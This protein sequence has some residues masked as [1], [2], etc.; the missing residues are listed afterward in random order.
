MKPVSIIF[1]IVSVVLVI[2]GIVLCCV[3][4]VKANVSGVPLYD[5]AQ[6]ENGDAENEYVFNESDVS[7]IKIDV[8]S[9]DVKV[10]CGAEENK[11]VVKNIT[12]NNIVSA[13]DCIINN[14][15][16]SIENHNL[17]SLTSLAQG[18]FSFKGFRYGIKY[19][20]DGDKYDSKSKEVTVY[21]KDL[22]DIRNIDVSV[23]EGSIEIEGYDNSTDYTLKISNG[24]ITLKNVKTDSEVSA[25]VEKTG[26]VFFENVSCSL[27]DISTEQGNI[28]VQLSSNEIKCVNGGGDTVIESQNDLSQYNYN[29]SSPLGKILLNG[30]DK[31]SEYKAVDAMLQCEMRITAANGNLTVIPY[32]PEISQ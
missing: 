8:D 3:G 16:M 5:Y 26:N 10:I 4:M 25:C 29:L 21:V 32:V 6:S 20:F 2:V 22:C 23:G 24:N 31:G 17:F 1:L 19:V 7:R 27:A 11:V 15:T 28:D 18:Q 30:N 12:S 9:A 13:F 14:K